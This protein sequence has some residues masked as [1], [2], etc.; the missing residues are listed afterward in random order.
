M[1]FR[2]PVS[3]VSELLSDL[4][5]TTTDNINGVWLDDD[6]LRL[7]RTVFG[8]VQRFSIRRAVGMSIDY[9]AGG[10]TSGVVLNPAQQQGAG[11][12]QPLLELYAGAY[13]V[14][15]NGNGWWVVPRGVQIN[16]KVLSG[17]E[18]ES[19][20]FTVAG[21]AGR[22]TVPHDLGRTPRAVVVSVLQQS[23]YRA[24]PLDFTWNASSFQVEFR[25]LSNALAPNGTTFRISYIATTGT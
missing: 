6:G 21:G 10:R 8:E 23:S 15:L 22:I 12:F 9:V 18:H 16:G 24:H 5:T 17:M 14:W 1:A 7:V 13:R 3:R 2:S 25:D 11:P 19:G 4:F 20:T